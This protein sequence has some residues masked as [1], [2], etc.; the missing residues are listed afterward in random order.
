[1]SKEKPVFLII[2]ELVNHRTPN[3]NHYSLTKAYNVAN[4][5]TSFAS[6]LFLTTSEPETV[7]N[8]DFVNKLDKKIIDKIDNVLFIRETNIHIIL[9]K[10]NDLK[11]ALDAEDRKIK[12]GIK[13]DSLMW[14]KNKDLSKWVKNKYRKGVREWSYSFFDVLYVQIPA[15]IEPA[16]K[17]LK[18]D[19]DKKLRTSKMGVPPIP[20]DFDKVDNKFDDVLY[21]DTGRELKE[22]S[23]LKPLKKTR[24]FQSLAKMDTECTI[25]KPIKLIYTGRIKTDQGRIAVMMSKIMKQLG[26]DYQL[27]IFPGKF[28]IPDVEVRDYSPKNTYHLQFLRDNVFYNNDNVFIHYPFDHGSRLNYLCHVDIGLDFSPTRPLDSQSPYG[29]SKLLD[30]CYA[31]LPVVTEKNVGNIHLV[32]EANNG[33]ILR[34]NASVEDYVAAI[35]AVSKLDI[36]RKKVSEITIANNSWE[37]IC[38]DI[39]EDFA[40]SD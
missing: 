33:I 35:K 24:Y 16:M 23:A 12:V 3:R 15:S 36:D 40:G 8:I 1:M 4:Y 29:N 30:Y 14:L 20:V 22:N 19:D 25:D 32:K 6:V 11:E 37:D 31:G 39:A 17:L 34:D 18:S 27:H 21:V 5:M 2:N 28:V 10:F 38:K 7:N 26:N 9:E 13:S